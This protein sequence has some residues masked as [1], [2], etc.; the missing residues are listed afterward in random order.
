MSTPTR[1]Y[2]PGTFRGQRIA[3][4]ELF[5][6]TALHRPQLWT[7]VLVRNLLDSFAPPAASPRT[8]RDYLKVLGQAV[9]T[10]LSPE[11][12]AALWSEFAQD[13]RIWEVW[14]IS[15]LEAE[16]P[17][18]KKALQSQ[19]VE[20][21]EEI[22]QFSSLRLERSWLPPHELPKKA[23]SLALLGYL[24]PDHQAKRIVLQ[25]IRSRV[26]LSYE[27]WHLYL[28]MRLGTD[29]LFRELTKGPVELRGYRFQRNLLEEVLQ[30]YFRAGL[31]PEGNPLTLPP[32]EENP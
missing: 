11:R 23:D 24:G 31:V 30:A 7:E 1:R 12:R 4:R 21:L 9:E 32:P 6:V 18:L 19:N 22:A 15:T 27:D 20:Q 25:Q 14:R 29:F 17:G 26:Q 10:G 5:Q 28:G 16:F 3:A 8:R 2:L 13:P